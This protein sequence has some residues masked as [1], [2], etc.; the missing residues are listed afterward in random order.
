[1]HAMLTRPL[2]LIAAITAI[3]ATA[4]TP[5]QAHAY[6]ASGT[7]YKSADLCVRG[8]HSMR[9]RSPDAHGGWI[10]VRTYSATRNFPV[11]PV[12]VVHC[13]V[14]WPR[15]AL[16]I[17]MNVNWMVWYNTG[18]G[19][20]WG[21]CKQTGWVYNRYSSVTLAM[22]VLYATAQ[23]GNAWYLS[24]SMH[25]VANSGWYGGELVPSDS[26]WYPD[27]GSGKTSEAPPEVPD[28]LPARAP[29]IG[30][31]GQPVLD[32]H[33]APVMADT[34]PPADMTA[35]PSEHH[36]VTDSDGYVHETVDITE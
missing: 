36:T 7:L 17:R 29:V 8:Y 4:A 33:G 27:Y 3:T 11:P 28:A 24:L 12:P 21:L 26:H 25:G 20:A 32:Q 1:M 35:S 13:S 9:H 18:S 22:N 14:Y 6:T 19:F 30:P 5:A 10:D 16:N 23:C 2:A 15:P 31:D 34:A